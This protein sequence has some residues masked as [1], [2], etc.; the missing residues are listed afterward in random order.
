MQTA[1]QGLRIRSNAVPNMRRPYRGAVPIRRFA[2][3]ALA[4]KGSIPTADPSHG[5]VLL[6]LPD[7]NATSAEI[8]PEPEPTAV[9]ELGRLQHQD[10]YIEVE[11]TTE[12]EEVVVEHPRAI[13]Q[14]AQT[15]LTATNVGRSVS[16]AAVALLLVTLAM[17]V[18][19]VNQKANTPSAKRQRLIA[20]NK[21]LVTELSKRLPTQRSSLTNGTIKGLMRSTGFTAIEVFRKYLWYL[22]RERKFDDDA[23]QDLVALKAAAN[24]SD[25]DVAEALSERAQRIYDQYG[26]L[27]LNTD[28]FTTSGLERKATCKALFQKMLYLTECDQLVAQSSEAATRVDLR[29]IFGAT[30]EDLDKMRMVSLFDVDLEKI[31]DQ[32]GKIPDDTD[33]AEHHERM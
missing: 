11:V 28:G 26:T 6:H 2:R 16:F 21:Q 5:S 22:L 1:N 27:M 30:N 24:L 23:V 29:K 19:R 20:R 33:T 14:E 8:L 17:A 15:Y 32:S 13:L 4:P 3:G 18:H 25:D 12:T 9:I 31:F 10:D 7:Q